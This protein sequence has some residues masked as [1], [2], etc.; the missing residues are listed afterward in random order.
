MIFHSNS[1][2]QLFLLAFNLK[3]LLNLHSNFLRPLPRTLSIVL[4]AT[5]A[6]FTCI[7]NIGFNTNC[8]KFVELFLDIQVG[9]DYPCE[10]T[11]ALSISLSKKPQF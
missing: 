4:E 10:Y 1:Y 11:F 8:M 9:K 6:C 2:F 5:E 3:R 7:S